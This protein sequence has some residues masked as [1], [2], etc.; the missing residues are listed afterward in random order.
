MSFGTDYVTESLRKERPRTLTTANLGRTIVLSLA[1]NRAVSNLVS[2]YGFKLGARRFVAGDSLADAIAAAGELNRA[3]IAVTL[4]HLGEL[5]AEPEEAV[6]AATEGVAVLDA[7][8]QSGV[9]SNLSLK[10]TQ[11]GLDIDPELCWRNLR[12]VVSR[13]AELH[14]FVRIDM[15]DSSRVPATIE[16]FK[17]LRAEYS[18]VGLVLQSYLYRSEADQRE[19]AALKANLR[20]VKGAYREPKEVAYPGKADVDANYLRLVKAHLRAGNYTAVATHDEKLIGEAIRFA[21]EA[22]IPLDRF[23]FQMLFG[24]RKGLQRSLAERGFKVRVYVPYGRQWY[25]YFMRRLAERPA[26]ILFV[27][28]NL[29]RA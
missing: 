2:R 19:L 5:V 14:N 9:D 27:L 26:N 23:E 1:G 4:D 25:P 16:I 10:L 22:R 13:A 18:N 8:A 29:L 11:L 20:V 15:E 17:R 21:E 12:R 24:I 3:G 28:R 7:I 6:N